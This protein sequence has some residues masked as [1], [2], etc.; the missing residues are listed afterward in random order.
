M[1]V[2]CCLQYQVTQRCG[3]TTQTATIKRFAKGHGGAPKSHLQP[4]S[5]VENFSR[6]SSVHPDL[7]RSPNARLSLSGLSPEVGTAAATTA[8]LYIFP[9]TFFFAS[10]RCD[11]GHQPPYSIASNPSSL[12]FKCGVTLVSVS[13]RALHH[14]QAIAA[15]RRRASDAL[16][17]DTCSVIVGVAYVSGEV[18]ALRYRF[19]SSGAVG[20]TLE[21]IAACDARP[22]NGRFRGPSVIFVSTLPSLD[23]SIG[24]TLVTTRFTRLACAYQHRFRC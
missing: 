17:A 14:V 5:Q 15:C 18:F 6:I 8:P 7:N 19:P 1:Q 21:R 16:Y 23:D 11:Y 12:S 3:S 10:S 9:R 20:R 22:R 4:E 24:I 13:E 2:E